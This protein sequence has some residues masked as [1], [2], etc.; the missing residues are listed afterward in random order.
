VRACV[1]WARKD[2]LKDAHVHGSAS[3]SARAVPVGVCAC[4][5]MRTQVC[6][7][8]ISCLLCSVRTCVNLVREYA[9]KA[10]LVHGSASVSA[11]AV[12]VG[13]CACARMRTQVSL[14]AV[15]SLACSVRAC[16]LLKCALAL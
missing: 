9:M 12:P 7:L 8:A 10:A 15:S 2:A 14:L 4:A 5:R 3:V 11:R 6:L 1:S 16:V 13:V